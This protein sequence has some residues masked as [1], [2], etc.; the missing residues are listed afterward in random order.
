MNNERLFL[1]GVVDADFPV[2]VTL[3]EGQIIA[4][5]LVNYTDWSLISIGIVRMSLPCIFMELIYKNIAVFCIC[6]LAGTIE[7]RGKL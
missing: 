7:K 4:H 5:C 2:P 6:G 3:N 1:I